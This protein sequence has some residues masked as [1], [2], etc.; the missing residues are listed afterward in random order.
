MRC[1]RCSMPGRR[2]RSEATGSWRRRT[3]LEG[4][5]AAVTRRTLDGKT[6]N[7]WVPE[8]KITV[9][10]ALRA[11]TR[12]SAFAAFQDSSVGVLRAGMLADLV[13]IDRDLTKEVAGE[14][15]RGARADDG[16]GRTRGVRTPLTVFAS[17]ARERP[18][19]P[20]SP[21]A[22]RG[23]G[24]GCDMRGGRAPRAEAALGDPRPFTPVCEGATPHSL[25]GFPRVAHARTLGRCPLPTRALPRP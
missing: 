13:L 20:Q 18:R 10:E 3:P 7:G 6:P 17:S 25:G 2:W 11:Y 15:R 14:A 9:E 21:L 4:I 19:V 8:Q 24:D 5:Y 23:V 12:G 1:A 16:G 22:A